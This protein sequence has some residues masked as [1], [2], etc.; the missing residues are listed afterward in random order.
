MADVVIWKFNSSHHITS[1]DEEHR[2]P[3]YQDRKLIIDDIMDELRLTNKMPV[4]DPRDLDD[5]EED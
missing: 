4:P 2:Q 1:C 5:K 3:T